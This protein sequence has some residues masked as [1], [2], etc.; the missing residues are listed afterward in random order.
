MAPTISCTAD[1]HL[2][3]CAALSATNST[4]PPSTVSI[5]S[6]CPLEPSCSSRTPFTA[7][8]FGATE[9]KL[10]HCHCSEP[11]S[12]L[13]QIT[14]TVPSTSSSRTHRRCLCEP[15]GLR[16]FSTSAVPHAATAAS[17]RAV[18]STPSEIGS[19]VFGCIGVTCS[20]AAR[21]MP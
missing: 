13:L 7:R 11:S 5:A 19:A 2:A 9:P 16:S 4:S 12:F 10:F 20:S 18:A 8:R 15:S 17:S 21:T 3:R 1:S 14:N 6:P